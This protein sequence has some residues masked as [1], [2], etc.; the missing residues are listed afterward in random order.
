MGIQQSIAGAVLIVALLITL[1]VK[2]GT[3]V[4]IVRLRERLVEA[5]TGVRGLRTQLKGMENE[6]AVSDSQEKSLSG[7]KKQLEKQLL[8]LQ[9]ELQGLEG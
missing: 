7:Q 3:T 9:K 8:G 1:A 4:Q 2:Y 5:E 6:R